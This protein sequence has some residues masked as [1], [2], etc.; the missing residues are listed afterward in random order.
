MRV[1]QSLI[2]FNTVKNN[3]LPQ[4]CY[5]ELEVSCKS[6][7]YS[8]ITFSYII[9]AIM[10]SIL[11]F[12]PKN[13]LTYSHIMAIYEIETCT[14]L[15]CLPFKIKNNKV[16]LTEGKYSK[17][18]G[19][20][21]LLF[22]S[23][24]ISAFFMKLTYKLLTTDLKTTEMLWYTGWSSLISCCY[25]QGGLFLKKERNCLAEQRDS[26]SGKGIYRERSKPK[27]FLQEHF[28]WLLKKL[29]VYLQD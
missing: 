10:N 27:A 18:C 6:D 28:L 17:L 8:L 23:V 9:S 29:F 21:N 16:V 3:H 13:F 5:N 14:I 24:M 12:L 22:S 15:N 4:Y 1:V 2:V 20:A 11:K 26:W 19:Y 7:E 25:I